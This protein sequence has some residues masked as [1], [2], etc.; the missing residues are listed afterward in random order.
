MI[1]QELLKMT[2]ILEIL[3]QLERKLLRFIREKKILN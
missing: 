1:I 2:Q 3:S